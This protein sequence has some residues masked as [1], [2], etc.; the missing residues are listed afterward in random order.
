M[1]KEKFSVTKRL[2]SVGF[3]CIGLKTLFQHEHNFRIHFIA[4][5]MAVVLGFICKISPLEWIAVCFSIGMVMTAE[6][7]NTALEN[8]AD[9]VSPDKHNSIKTIKD[10]SAA[11]VLISALCALIVGLIIFLPKMFC[12]CFV[13]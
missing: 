7:I 12:S 4:A 8:L 1:N 6:A 9:F 13:H 11:A 5:T 10:V 2:K 3:A